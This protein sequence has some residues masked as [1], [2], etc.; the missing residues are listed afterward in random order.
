M[1]KLAHSD[2]RAMRQIEY[3]SLVRDGE[4]KELPARCCGRCQHWTRGQPDDFTAPEGRCGLAGQPL[5]WPVGYWPATLQRDLCPS[6]KRAFYI[7]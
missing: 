1:S 6:F 2:E 4:L 3:D 7:R 5:H